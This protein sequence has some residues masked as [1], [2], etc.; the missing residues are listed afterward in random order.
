MRQG[1][2]M[3]TVERLT[4]QEALLTKKMWSEIFYEDSDQFTDY[5]Y[6]EK[7]G[8]NIGYGLKEDGALRSMLFL[9]PYTGA[10]YAPG[11]DGERF[12]DVSLSYIVGV[13]T[14]QA[15]R[16]RGYMGRLLRAALMDLHRGRQPFTFLMPADPAI[17]TP[18]QFRYIYDRPAFCVSRRER[19]EISGRSDAP[20]ARGGGEDAPDRK[21]RVRAMEEGEAEQLAAFANQELERRFQLF[22]RRDGAYYKRQQKE[23]RAMNGDVYLWKEAGEIAGFYLYAKEGGVEEIQ[24]AMVRE[25]LTGKELLHISQ[26]VRPILMGRITN[27]CSMLSLLRLRG[28]VRAEEITLCFRLQDALICEHNATFL[29]TVGKKESTITVSDEEERAE[30]RIEIGA[31][32]EFV[33]GRADCRTCFFM[34]DGGEALCGSGKQQAKRACAAEPDFF[35]R[36]RQIEPLTRLCINEI[37]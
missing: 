7:M 29:W 31:L 8:H 23:S 28:S 2:K 1:Q 6:E 3:E 18:Y 11:R 19:Q 12:R 20:A 34:E 5:Y 36:L 35:E 24:E 33:F 4:R 15:Y 16:R 21:I 22:L 9:T 37:V 17:Y 30:A 13:G 25:D 32:T 27:V 10:V 26:K 14:G